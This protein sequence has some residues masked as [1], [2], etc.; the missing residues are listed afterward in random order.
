MDEAPEESNGLA[1]KEHIMSGKTTLN[2]LEPAQTA[3]LVVHM[4]KGVAGEVDTPFSRL[5]R[6]RAKETGI[7]KAQLR[8]LDAFRRAKA[9][10]L[11]TAVTYQ[12]GLPGISPNSPLW[13]TL[14]DCVCLMEGTPAVELIDEL[15]R[16]PDESLVRGQAANGFDRTVL[17][18]VLRVA[19]VDTLVLAGIATDVAVESTARAASDLQYRT[20]VVSDA[21]I[22]DTDEAHTH[23]LD[24]IQK[25]FG[26]TPT[27]DE[28]LSALGREDS[29][30]R[31]LRRTA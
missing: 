18:T 21:C 2:S 14:F 23:A 6:R 3:L 20:I 27:A 22:A 30:V 15:A 13:R 17:D 11:Y 7:I 26:E 31:S 19:G 25:W 5:F 1:R 10:V 9:K 29:A 24:A 4:V 16:R 8:L 28:V 12:T